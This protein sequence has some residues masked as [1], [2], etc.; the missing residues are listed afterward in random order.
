MSVHALAR[1]S[2]VGPRE[3]HD[4]LP[5][6]QSLRGAPAPA[7]TPCVD[8][9]SG[10]ADHCGDDCA[11]H[12]S[13]A[14]WGPR[15][16][17]ALL[18]LLLL[19]RLP[20]AGGEGVEGFVD[21]G[22]GECRNA[23][24]D[25][26]NNRYSWTKTQAECADGA[27]ANSVGY[28]YNTVN[29]CCR[30]H[31]QD[32]FVGST[33]GSDQSD[34][35][36]ADGPI[37]YAAGDAGCGASVRCYVLLAPAPAPASVFVDIGQG[38]CR[39]ADGGVVNNRFS[40]TKT[41]AECADGAFANGMGYSYNTGNSC[42]RMHYQDAFVGSTSG[43]AQSVSCTADGHICHAECDAGCSASVLL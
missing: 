23:D 29:D 42:C 7:P 17:A 10:A 8:T 21:I 3:P 9:V 32:A 19:C 28:S 13:D 38:E 22:Q 40:W 39:N 33:S 37:L 11:V 12:T 41:Q 25:V 24:G 16:S 26:V 43:S 34:C 18:A 6:D 1:G 35:C 14:P 2:F 20:Q 15:A 30:M 4:P 36:V 31:Y 27:F 5:P